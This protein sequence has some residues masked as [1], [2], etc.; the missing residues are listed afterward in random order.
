MV[1]SAHSELRQ[2]L[3]LSSPAVSGHCRQGSGVVRVLPTP[4]YDELLG[5]LETTGGS[6]IVKITRNTD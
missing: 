4:S 3:G 6:S 1:S 2:D 5:G